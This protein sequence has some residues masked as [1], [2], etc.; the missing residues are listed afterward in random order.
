MVVD[1]LLSD[2]RIFEF[3]IERLKDGFMVCFTS[4]RLQPYFLRYIVSLRVDV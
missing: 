4:S 3:V 2:K 1:I